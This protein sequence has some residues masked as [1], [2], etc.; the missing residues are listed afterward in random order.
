M[1]MRFFTPS[2]LRIFYTADEYGNNYGT[3]D[4]LVDYIKE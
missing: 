3:T 2:E 4:E 1:H